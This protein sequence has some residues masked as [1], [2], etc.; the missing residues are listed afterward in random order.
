MEMYGL[1]SRD[2][3]LPVVKATSVKQIFKELGVRA[4]RAYG[5]DPRVVVNGLLTREKLGST[6]I[7][8]GVAIPHA[9]LAGLASYVGLFARLETLV[10]FEAADG[11]WV[12]LVFVILTP[13]NSNA[14]HLRNLAR[15]S[16]LFSNSDLREKLRDTSEAHALYVL[17]TEPTAYQV[18]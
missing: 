10:D 9:R 11:Q 8:G 13:K 4:G 15:V 1:I 14:E 3:I 18:A 5:L 12:D 6:A 2:S 17:I 16:R 7:G